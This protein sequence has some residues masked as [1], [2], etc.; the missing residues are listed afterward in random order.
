MLHKQSGSDDLGRWVWQQIRVDGVRSVYI[1]TA[2]QVCPKPPSTS[3]MKT[4]W[5]QQYRG[6]VRKGLRNPDPRERFM[7]DPGKFLIEIRNDGA[8]FILGWDATRYG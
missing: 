5:H 6:L 8:D 3:K 1:I 4:A 7:F 2:Y